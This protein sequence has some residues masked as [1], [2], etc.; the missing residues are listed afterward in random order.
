MNYILP[1]VVD[2]HKRKGT[3]LHFTVY[4]GRRV[5]Y[6]DE[7]IRDSKWANKFYQRLDLYEK[8]VRRDLWD[9][10]DELNGAVLGCW[11]VNTDKLVPLKCHG[12]V[13][14]KLFAEKF[15][16]NNVQLLPKNP[17]TRLNNVQ[18]KLLF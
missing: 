4:I 15:Q 8:H 3:R 11:C 10:L 2:L 5:Q 1:R 7:F 6:H 13:L 9:E 12:Q 16:L 14:M 17:K 18:K